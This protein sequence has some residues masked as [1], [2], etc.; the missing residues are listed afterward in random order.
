MN[1]PANDWERV[2]GLRFKLLRRLFCVFT[3]HRYTD[4]EG[5]PEPAEAHS[6]LVDELAATGQL[7]GVHPEDDDE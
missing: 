6:R 4:H 7:P 2:S 5:A 3:D 1:R